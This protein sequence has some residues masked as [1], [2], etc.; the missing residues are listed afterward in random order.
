MASP[1]WS[2]TDLVLSQWRDASPSAKKTLAVDGGSLTI[3]DVVAVSRDLVQVKLTTESIKAMERCSKIIPEKIAKGDIIYGVNTGFGGSAD[4]RSNDVER[5][6]QSLISHLT[7][8]IVADGKQQGVVSLPLNDAL[9]ATCMPESWARASMLIRLNSLAGGASGIRVAIAESLKALLNKDVVPRIPVRGSIS[10][11]GDLSALAWIGALMQG[12]PSATAFAGP[13][14]GQGARGV[15]RADAALSAAGIEP[16]QL[17]AKEGLAIVNGTAVSAG[18]AALAAHECL[19]LAALSQVLTAMSVEALRGSDESFEPFIA[20]VRPHAGQ[21]DS[22]RNIKAFLAGS[23]LLHRHDDQNVATLRQDRYSLRTASQWIGPVLEDFCLAHHQLT[24]ELNAVTDNP[25]I[26]AA[27]GRIYHG[28]NFQARAVTSAAEKLRQ[29][30]QTIGR[31]LFSQCTELMNPATSWG[32]PPNLCSDDANHSFLFKGIDVIVAGLTSELGFL[33]NPVGS[34]VQTAEMGNQSLNSL[35]LVSARY[36]L[37]A[38][39]V[40]SQLSAAHLL[41]LCQALD[42]RAIECGG[43]TDAPPDA[44]PFLGH[45]SRRMYRF[46]RNDLGIPFLGEEH[47]ASTDAATPDGVTPSIGLYNT[48]VYES[49]RS[50]RLYQVV[51]ESLREVNEQEQPTNG[52]VANSVSPP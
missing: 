27:A 45:A 32:L 50:G 44:T 31:M 39:D 7:C 16:I 2:F 37:D 6:Q 33:A 28:G 3:A 52:I 5:V 30:L 43:R 17:H 8:G 10:A 18:V 22:A 47:L 26:D 40:L 29:G 41:A 4:T 51:L 48:R 36:T 35:G 15:T 12:K 11:S 19:H 13:R 42:L 34:H 1:V 25:L 21:I 38:V 49:I 20:R 46:L 24:V 14:D 23:R 9:A